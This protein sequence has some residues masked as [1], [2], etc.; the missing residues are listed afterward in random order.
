M[1]LAGEQ[2]VKAACSRPII[3]RVPILYGG[4]QYLAESA[5]LAIAA[6]I[7]PD[8]ESFHDDEATRYPSHVDDVAAVIGGLAEIMKNELSEA[9]EGT[10]AGVYQWS[11]ETALTKYGMALI[12]AGIMGVDRQL[13][14]PSKPDPNAAP[15][16]KNSHLD[17]ERLR[18][19]GIGGELDFAGELRKILNRLGKT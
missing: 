5:V 15:R 10:V 11:G 4:E 12:M 2:R 18:K 14:K 19:L 13:I 7:K 16:P 9:T 3:I 17:T 6:G 1:K 8:T